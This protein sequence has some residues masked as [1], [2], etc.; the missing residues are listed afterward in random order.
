MLVFVPARESRNRTIQRSCARSAT[1]MHCSSI[2]STSVDGTAQHI[3]S[4]TISR[5]PAPAPALPHLQFDD[6]AQFWTV[7]TFLV[8]VVQLGQLRHVQFVALAQLIL[9]GFG[10]QGHNVREIYRR[11]DHDEHVNVGPGQQGKVFPSPREQG[12]DR[13]L[14]HEQPR[15]PPTLH[16]VVQEGFAKDE[17]GTHRVAELQRQP[18]EPRASFQEQP[19]RAGWYLSLCCSIV[20]L[21]TWYRLQGRDLHDRR[22]LEASRQQGKRLEFVLPGLRSIIALR[23]LVLSLDVALHESDHIRFE[24]AAGVS[25][26]VA[27]DAEDWTPKQDGREAEAHLLLKWKYVVHAR[28]QHRQS[29]A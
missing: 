28:V 18:Q 23:T 25:D 15:L 3:R 2:R 13:V 4:R 17:D 11:A 5:A 6:L 16:V 26:E 22:L 14:I 1:A 12:G 7:S 24:G 8:V 29:H 9:V 10:V 20:R 27:E 19:F 21:G